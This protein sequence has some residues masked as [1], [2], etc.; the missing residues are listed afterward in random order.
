MIR[1]TWYF[2]TYYQEKILELKIVFL[3]T[4]GIF[5]LVLICYFIG[6]LW[7][8]MYVHSSFTSRLSNLIEWQSSRLRQRN[9]RFHLMNIEIMLI[10]YSRIWKKI[11]NQSWPLVNRCV[12]RKLE[13]SEFRYKETFYCF[14]WRINHHC[15]CRRNCN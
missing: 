8:Q 7:F 6:F 5:A 1:I 15:W 9:F 10:I 11:I 12:Q 13:M 4:K 14:I 2:Q 3:T